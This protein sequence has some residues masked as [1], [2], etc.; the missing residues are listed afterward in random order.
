MEETLHHLECMKPCKEWDKLPARISFHQHLFSVFL[1]YEKKSSHKGP[2][3]L[4]F[5][6]ETKGL[7]GGVPEGRVPP[8]GSAARNRSKFDNHHDWSTLLPPSQQ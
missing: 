3:T 4:G 5:S 6:E 7:A 1:I 2:K 8:G